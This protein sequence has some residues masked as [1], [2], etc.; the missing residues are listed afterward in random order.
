MYIDWVAGRQPDYSSVDYSK[1]A[2]YSL[3]ILGLTLLYPE[4]GDGVLTV[5]GAVQRANCVEVSEKLRKVLVSMLS[6]DVDGRPNPEQLGN[7][8]EQLFPPDVVETLVGL[9]NSIEQKE[10]G[11]AK[12][13]LKTVIAA[14]I[15]A[16]VEFPCSWC[17]AK[18]TMGAGKGLSFCKQHLICTVVCLMKLGETYKPTEAV[19]C[20]LCVRDSVPQSRRKLIIKRLAAPTM[21]LPT[22]QS[23]TALSHLT[24]TC[25]ACGKPFEL[26]N[27][28]PWRIDLLGSSVKNT[29]AYCSKACVPAP[30]S[31]PGLSSL[32]QDILFIISLEG[33]NNYLRR[34]QLTLPMLSAGFPPDF[35]EYLQKAT[36]DGITQ[37]LAVVQ[38]QF[39]RYN[40]TMSCHLCGQTIENVSFGRWMMCGDQRTFVCSLD[41]FRRILDI[42]VS[43]RQ[44]VSKECPSCGGRIDSSNIEITLG[45]GRRA[46]NWCRRKYCEPTRCGHQSCQGC[47]SQMNQCMD[48]QLTRDM[49]VHRT[50]RW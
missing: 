48:C 11:V 4:I 41:C 13:E 25:E 49:D 42:P 29:D 28:D 9:N 10:F 30:P 5:E 47:L 22:T 6:G 46:C 14:G 34:L 44:V 17:T 27:S 26:E 12:G 40:E 24:A 37:D 20:P 35:P 21:E 36:T 1:A 7:T 50:G 19:Q 8:L 32:E 39:F 15:A 18:V 2:V 3:G 43:Q 16:R 23:G 38:D 31:A 33:M 45:I